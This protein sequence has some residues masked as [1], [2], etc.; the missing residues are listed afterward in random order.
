MFSLYVLTLL[1][2]SLC[3]LDGE[4]ETQSLSKFPWDIQ[5]IQWVPVFQ[6]LSHAR[7]FVAPWTAA[8]RASVPF[9]ISWT[10]LKLVSIEWEMPSSRLILCRH[11]LLSGQHTISDQVCVVR[12][13]TVWQGTGT[14]SASAPSVATWCEELGLLG[15]Q[16]SHVIFIYTEW[17]FYECCD[18]CF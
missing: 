1:R 6:S 17:S 7:L 14:L 9:T 16:A 4:T 11:P 5:V 8:C 3:F 18:K 15:K 10:L 2:Q 12:S 13:A